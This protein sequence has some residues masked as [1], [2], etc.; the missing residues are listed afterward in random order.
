M[1]V[2]TWSSLTPLDTSVQSQSKQ[3]IK[4]SPFVLK[5]IILIRSKCQ[6]YK[7]PCTDDGTCRTEFGGVCNETQ[8][9]RDHYDT[10]YMCNK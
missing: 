2:P 6:C 10:G 9:S 7:R 3:N 8:P 5:Q 4:Y 1:M